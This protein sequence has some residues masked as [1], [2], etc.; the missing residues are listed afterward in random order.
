[1]TPCALCALRFALCA[2]RFAP[3]PTTL[4]QRPLLNSARIK[5]PSLT[6]SPDAEALQVVYDPTKIEYR[7]LLEFFYKM[8]DPT[9]ANRQGPDVGS[10]YR[11]AIFYHDA[12]QEK[13][14][15]EITK[16]VDEQWWKGAVATEVLPAG[17]WWDAE[18]YHQKY[19]DGNPGGYECPSHFLR[20]FPPLS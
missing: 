19:L 16:Q 20:S 18:A 14:A 6:L 12:E 17:Q 8:H 9:T 2:L 11:S 5:S 1:M 3:Q 15:K 4:A 13:I 10:Q 7:S